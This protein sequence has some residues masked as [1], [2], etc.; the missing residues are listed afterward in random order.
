LFKLY[1]NSHIVRVLTDVI[2]EIWNELLIAFIFAAQVILI[3]AI[4]TFHFE[5]VLNPNI[6]TFFDSLYYT[7]ISI[8]TV[9]FGDINPVT[10]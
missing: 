10:I 2:K 6:N 4:L 8:T 1:R 3:S 7:I 5:N 9:G